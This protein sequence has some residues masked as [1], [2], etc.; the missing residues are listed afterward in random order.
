VITREE[1]NQVAA[2]RAARLEAI[3]VDVFKPEQYYQAKPGT[4]GIYF[5][6]PEGVR[7]AA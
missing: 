3:E 6:A 4:E 5:G 7:I 2:A 1:A